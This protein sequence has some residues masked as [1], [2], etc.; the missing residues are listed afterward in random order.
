MTKLMEKLTAKSMVKS[1]FAVLFSVCLFGPSAWA[2]VSSSAQGK[3]QSA[4]SAQEGPPPAGSAEPTQPEEAAPSTAPILYISSVEAISS[5]HGPT[6]HIIRVRG[7]ASTE[8]WES[9]EL[10][11]L[12]KGTPPDG[13]LDLAFIAQAPSDETAPSKSPVIEAVFTLEPGHPYKG[14][15]VHS[16]TNRVTLKSLPGYAEAPPPP[17]DCTDCVG[18]YFVG[19]GETPPAGASS[20]NVVREEN[21]P[22]MLHVVKPT[23]GI[24]KLDSDPNRLTIV[25]GEDGRIVIA[26]WD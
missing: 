9:A 19:K 16:A 26:V 10:V 13:M 23:D 2:Q 15:R 8:G 6:L 22:K 4:P 7:I 14:V 20:G 18:K 12:T 1:M 11:P 21:L 3:S 24:G 5:A 25:L 17:D